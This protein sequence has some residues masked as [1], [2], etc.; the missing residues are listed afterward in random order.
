MPLIFLVG[1]RA[2]GKTTIGRLLAQ[3]LA[4]PFIDTDHY[5]HEQMGCSVSQIVKTEGWPSFRKRESDALRAV[6]AIHPQG[7]VIATG[8]G[9]VLDEQ[10]RA[11]MRE[12]GHV[13]Y[14]SAPEEVLVG[15]LYNNPLSAQRPSLTG[16][17][18]RD[19]VWQVLRERLPLYHEVAHH[20]L[21]A[22]QSPRHI[23]SQ[24]MDFLNSLTVLDAEAMTCCEADRGV[25]TEEASAASPLRQPTQHGAASDSE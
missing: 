18:F 9:M 4:L 20:H 24:A 6:A 22:S 14:L 25:E 16:A 12:H 15:R 5:L 2:C 23:T 21:D 17:D 7:A 8:G 1:P 13:F 11:F 3:R 10:N 19:E